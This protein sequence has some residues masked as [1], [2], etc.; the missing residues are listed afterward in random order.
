M[1]YSTLPQLNIFIAFYL[2]VSLILMGKPWQVRIIHHI[3]GQEWI[4]LF[5]KRG[6]IGYLL[7]SYIIMSHLFYLSKPSF[8]H[9]SKE[10]K[11][12]LLHDMAA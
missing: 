2:I 8:H 7:S 10:T 5:R 9:L 11:Y 4:Q 1:K 6:L 3:P 12:Y